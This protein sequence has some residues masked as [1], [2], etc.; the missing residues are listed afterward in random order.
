MSQRVAIQRKCYI[1]WSFGRETQIAS[2]WH[3]QAFSRPLLVKLA[4]EK[5][6]GLE[7]RNAW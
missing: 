2:E 6:T 3:L 5:F 4:R 7:I 1:V